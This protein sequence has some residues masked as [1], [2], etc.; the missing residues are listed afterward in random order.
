MKAITTLSTIAA[1]LTANSVHGSRI[2]E[3]S[4]AAPKVLS[5]KL[6][7]NQHASSPADLDRRLAAHRKR[8]ANGVTVP[9]ENNIFLYYTNI[10]VGTPPQPFLVH[11]DT[12]SSDL[13]L[14]Y[15]NSDFCTSPQEPCDATGTYIANDSSTYE[16]VNSGF[17]I[18]YV[19]GSQ[20][21]GDYA[22]DTLTLF[23]TPEDGDEEVVIPAQQFGI[24]YESSTD[25]GILGIGYMANE[26]QVAYGGQPY[27]NLPQSLVDEGFINTNA[28]S[29]W[30]N[31]VGATEGELLFGGVDTA[32]YT[33][34]LVTLPIVPTRG[35]YRELT[36][37]LT[38]VGLNSE[39][40]A[41]SGGEINEEVHLDTG[42]SLTYLPDD[43]AEAMYERFEAVYNEA[44]GAYLM[45]CNPPGVQDL[46]EE[47][48]S[49]R[50][51]DNLSIRVSLR[52]MILPFATNRATG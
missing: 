27:P 38:G 32:K 29:I 17:Q 37:L 10:T 30:L 8:Q 40:E 31:D 2:S 36:V 13:W 43:I 51:A 42:A 18:S 26:V 3:R 47:Y 52:E 20:S 46:D 34:D 6:A 16:F 48:I 49:F 11:L 35:V 7:R 9:L 50:F 12:G 21:A 4:D 15:A 44:Q 33:G 5:Q 22:R 23:P 45:N 24:G 39:A 25:D 19:D 1:L 28:Y 41:F 14:N